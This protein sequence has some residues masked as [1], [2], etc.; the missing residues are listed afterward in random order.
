M[1]VISALLFFAPLWKKTSLLIG[2][3]KQIT[4]GMWRIRAEKA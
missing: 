2:T 4:I 3:D 1:I